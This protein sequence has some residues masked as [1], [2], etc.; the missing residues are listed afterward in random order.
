MRRQQTIDLTGAFHLHHVPG[1]V[2]HLDN[3]SGGS[4][5]R[6]FNWDYTIFATPKDQYA[7]AGFG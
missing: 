1:L 4:I 7:L 6:M 2:K 5:G 3:R